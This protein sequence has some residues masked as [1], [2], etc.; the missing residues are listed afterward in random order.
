MSGAWI[1]DQ[2]FDGTAR[3]LP[4]ASIGYLAQEPELPHETVQECVDEA[5]QSSR[6]ILDQY[7]VGHN[8]L[9]D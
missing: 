4:G 2:E 9:Y 1:E 6:D 7:T 8:F 5:V 3:P